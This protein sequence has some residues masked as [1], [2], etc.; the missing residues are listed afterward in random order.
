MKKINLKLIVSII[1][2]TLIVAALVLFALPMD[3]KANSTTTVSIDPTNS[4][5]NVWATPINSTFTINVTVTD[6][7]DLWNWQ[8]VLCF[9][10][11]MLH[12]IDAIVPTDSPFNFPIKGLVII[13]NVTGYVIM[14]ASQIGTAPGVNGS[15]VLA[16]MTFK[17][18]DAPTTQGESLTSNFTFCEAIHGSPPQPFN[19]FLADPDII[20]MPFTPINGTYEYNWP[21]VNTLIHEI[22]VDEQTYTVVTESNCTLNPVPMDFDLAEHALYF[23]I[24]GTAE[25][26]GYVNVTI[27]KDFMWDDFNVAVNGEQKVPETSA[28][29][30]HTFIYFTFNFTGADQPVAITA[31]SVVPEFSSTLI[32]LTML[33]ITTL[34]AAAILASRKKTPLKV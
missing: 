34:A 16:T 12:C 4:I 5:F 1:Y 26:A 17:I 24:S 21:S 23:N 3:V 10:T 25:N 13:D 33:L 15:G 19:T 28:N 22:V 8:A 11:S 32:M 27:P 6:V 29:D 31:E 2:P 7:I 30:T 14:G 9:N 18:I 20:E